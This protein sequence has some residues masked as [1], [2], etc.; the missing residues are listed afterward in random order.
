M[1]SDAIKEIK[2]EVFT[3][4]SEI[5]RLQSEVIDELFRLLAMHLEAE[6]LDRLPCIEK[7]NRAA[8]IRTELNK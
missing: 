5:I 1:I 8:A 3:S 2:L 6:E 7:I 4:Q